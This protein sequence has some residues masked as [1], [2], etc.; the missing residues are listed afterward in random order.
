RQCSREYRQLVR[1][2]AAEARRA[3]SCIADFGDE[4]FRCDNRLRALGKSERFG[5]IR[6]ANEEPF[7]CHTRIN[8]ERHR[9]SRSSRIIS[10]ALGY[11]TP[12]GGSRVFALIRSTSA[13]NSARL[14]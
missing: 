3:P 4:D 1:V 14:G 12:G 9:L 6:L 8:D 11:C 2:D 10:S 13:S 7:E 5:R